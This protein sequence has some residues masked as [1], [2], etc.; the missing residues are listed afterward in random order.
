MIKQYLIYTLAGFTLL[1]GCK[2]SE[3]LKGPADKSVA[4]VSFTNANASAKTV[5]VFSDNVQLN[6]AAAVAPN[7]TV[8]GTYVGIYPGT[9]LLEVKD[10]SAAAT[11]YHSNNIA[12]KAGNAYSYFVYDTLNAGRFRGLLLNS[13]RSINPAS[14][15]SKVRFLNLSPKAPALDVWFVRRVGAIAKDSLKIFAAV[16]S[17]TSVATPDATVLSA[18]TDV[19]SSQA[20]GAGGPG[21]LVTDYIIRLKLANTTTIVSSTAATTL[22]N[23]RAYT[24]FARGIFPSTAITSLFN[25]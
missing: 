6:N 25:N 21:S 1:A 10:I 15:T 16:P 18:Y 9:H 7:G 12:V 4:Y 14:T 22:V 19:A 24:F 20:A 8:T 5:N 2:K 17:L 3:G 11:F 13:D 23:G